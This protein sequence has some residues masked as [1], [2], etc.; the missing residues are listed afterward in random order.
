MVGRLLGCSVIL[1][2]RLKH[3]LMHWSLDKDQEVLTVDNTFISKNC[4]NA[5][6]PP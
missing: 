3:H 2:D 1:S 4:A 6:N 5:M